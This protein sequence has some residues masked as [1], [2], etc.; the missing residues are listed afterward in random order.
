MVYRLMGRGHVAALGVRSA[1][2]RE[3]GQGTVEYVALLV[4]VAL[5]LGAIVR[6]T[7]GFEGSTDIPKAIAEQLKEAIGQATPGGR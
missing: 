1:L 4:V 2:R 6:A 5:V 7:R 3:A